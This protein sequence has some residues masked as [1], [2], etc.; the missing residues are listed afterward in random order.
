MLGT[1]EVQ[2]VAKAVGRIACCQG[3]CSELAREL[4]KSCCPAE[5]GGASSL[6][7]SGGSAIMELGPQSHTTWFW[8]PDSILKLY[9]QTP[10]MPK[11]YVPAEARADVA[12]STYLP[13]L[14]CMAN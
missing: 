13:Q 7:G 12:S 4:L 6:R 3:D 10:M 1:L 11:V 5:A 9:L 14:Y 8:S 2:G